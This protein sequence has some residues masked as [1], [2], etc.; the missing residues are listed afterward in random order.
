MERAGKQ[1]RLITLAVVLVGIAVLYVARGVLIPFAL[2]MLVSFL[3]A[4]LVVQLQRWH[5]NRI[6]AV[7]TAVVLVSTLSILVS[8]F[9]VAQVQDVTTN[10]SMYRDN[11]RDRTET[12]RG[13]VAE[14]IR[15]VTRL[16]TDLGVDPPQEFA[17]DAATGPIQTVRIA[18]PARGVFQVFHD[19]VR[20]SVELMLRAAMVLLFAFMMLL[21]RDDLGD[22]FMHLVGQGKILVTTRAL[23]EASKRVSN[24]LWRLLLLNGLHG[25]AAG[26]GLAYI[27]VPNALLWGAMAGVLRFIPYVGP[28]VA[29]AFPVL[30]ALAVSPGWN[31]PLLVIGWIALL[32]LISNNLFEPWFLGSQ[33]G[34][35]PLALL[36][37]ALF[38]T[39]LWGPVGLV[40]STPLTVC[41]VVMG[42][43][44]PQLK[45][46]QLLIG[47]SPGLTPSGRLYQRLVAGDQ[48]QAWLVLRT[49]MELAFRGFS[50]A[51]VA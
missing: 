26:I 9:L 38:W 50:S 20:S 12:L 34:I 31:Q 28:W 24:Y 25:L 46:L 18:E 27:G 41:L 42:K 29:A 30:T 15:K 14:P 44:V 22:R 36:V 23:N 48:D 35:S 17:P 5:F 32:E 43:Y 3:L 8:W 39:W 33:M 4:P 11:I 37:S 40:L 49:E 47:D 16:A 13:L 10:L 51:G 6:V 1:T 21:R 45:F 19:A 2:A 7:V